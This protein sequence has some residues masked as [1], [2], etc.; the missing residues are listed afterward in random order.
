MPASYTQW[1]LKKRETYDTLTCRRMTKTKSSA[2]K[3]LLKAHRTTSILT[4]KNIST[5]ETVDEHIKNYITPLT[6]HLEE[7]SRKIQAHWYITRLLLGCRLF[8]TQIFREK[9]VQVQI[10]EHRV[11]RI[12]LQTVLLSIMF[13][14]SICAK[15]LSNIIFRW[16]ESYLFAQGHVRKLSYF[17]VRDI[18]LRF[19]F[20]NVEIFIRFGQI[21][22]FSVY[23][24]RRVHNLWNSNFLAANFFWRVI[25]DKSFFSGFLKNKGCTFEPCLYKKIGEKNVSAL[26]E[27]SPFSWGKCCEIFSQL[28]ST[29]FGG[30]RR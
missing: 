27:K 9:R 16:A 19:I 15:L 4:L 11:R 17:S 30:K 20:L 5:D 6:K 2:I 23:T 10:L 3:E 28:F 8:I 13:N 24:I 1:E 12:I 18:F 22:L 21:Y 14:Q 26:I 25:S 29:N 7:L